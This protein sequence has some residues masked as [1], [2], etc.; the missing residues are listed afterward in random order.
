MPDFLQI[1]AIVKAPKKRIIRQKIL[2]FMQDSFLLK[3]F[4]IKSLKLHFLHVVLVITI[5]IIYFH[6]MHL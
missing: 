3:A 2:Y 5:F 6:S 4:L 1:F